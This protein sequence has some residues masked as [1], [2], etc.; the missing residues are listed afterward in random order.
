MKVNSFWLIAI[1]FIGLWL[2]IKAG[3]MFTNLVSSFF[4]I[5]QNNNPIGNDEL[6][7]TTYIIVST[8]LYFLIVYL[9]VFKTQLIINVLRLNKG[10]D[11]GSFLFKIDKNRTL[12]IVIIFIGCFT[13]IETLPYIISNISRYFET[14]LRNEIEGINSP[15]SLFSDNIFYV[16]KLMIGY[17]LMVYNQKVVNLVTKFSK[18][19][20]EE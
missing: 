1:K 7:I 13:S 15:I 16:C 11:E 20:K 5:S 14:S 9:F 2:S 3:E 17:L 6:I 4:Q 19:E 18:D 8:F 12:K 10:F